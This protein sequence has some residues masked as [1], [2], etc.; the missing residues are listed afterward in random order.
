MSIITPQGVDLQGQAP[1]ELKTVRDSI[2][3]LDDITVVTRYK[4]LEVYIKNTDN[5]YALRSNDLTLWE[6]QIELRNDG[7]D[8]AYL[9]SWLLIGANG[10][11]QAVLDVDGDAM[12]SG[13]ITSPSIFNKSDFV[14]SSSG[15]ADADSPILLDANG[16]L[17]LSLLY[18]RWN[19]S[20]TDIFYTEGNVGIGTNTPTTLF[21]VDGDATVTGNLYVSGDI[22]SDSI[23][24]KSEYIAT[25]VGTADS[26]KPIITNQSGKIDSSLLTID[27]LHYIAG[28]TPDDTNPPTSEYPDTT[29]YTYG[30]FWVVSGLPTIQ[31]G[32]TFQSGDLIGQT[33]YNGDYMI[34]TESGW[35]RIDTG[36]NILDLYL[37]DGSQAITGPFAGGGQ[38]FKN[39]ADATDDQDLVT[40]KQYE[41]FVTNYAEP[42]FAKNSAFNKDFG[43]TY[44][45]V[46]EGNHNHSGIY[47]PVFTKNTA[48]NKNFGTTAGTVAEGNRLFWVAVSGGINYSTG[49]VGINNPSPSY[50]LDIIGDGSINGFESTNKALYVTKTTT[51]V[52]ANTTNYKIV[53]SFSATSNYDIAS[54][55]ID[56]GYRMGLDVAVHSDT[57]NLEGTLTGQYGARI[58][59][60]QYTN[61]GTGTI[62]NAYG[63]YLRGLDNGNTTITNKYGIYQ[64]GANFRN[65][66]Q[67]D[68]GIGATSPISRLE[69]AQKVATAATDGF[70]VGY[71]G[72]RMYA[73]VDSNEVRRID[74]A[75]TGSAVIALNGTGAGYVGIG[76]TIPTEVLEVN[77]N[78]KATD[79]ILSSDRRLKSNINVLD[80][81]IDGLTPVSYVMNKTGDLHYGFIAQDMLK[82]HPELVKGTGKEDADGT[83]DYYSIKANSII[84][85][86]VKEVQDLKKRIKELED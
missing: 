69:V 76:T 63:L 66:F 5:K 3:E 16:K 58:Q 17:D 32:Y 49:N 61:S 67:G 12:V 20:G 19:G 59:Y 30:A 27:S 11:P 65:Y 14:N 6:K 80:T 34:F 44:D 26:G 47:E 50:K 48:F 10:T 85:I 55:I 43:I 52:D 64:N 56:S 36:I 2:Q 1:V 81:S 82:T 13:I 37:L 83:I 23:F 51:T 4:G 53:S 68:V 21:Y 18:A 15:I 84:A 60:G 7:A 35:D 25:S 22:R 73:W 29:G 54:G 75:S 38:Q 39:A 31:S 86:L 40:K 72:Q 78:V 24:M 33:V 57:S 9:D 77:G 71:G 79:F 46:A 41:T 74:A 70:S 62:T 42:A 28:F 8:N 45:T